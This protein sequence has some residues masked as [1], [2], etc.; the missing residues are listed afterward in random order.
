LNND[1]VNIKTNLNTKT[2]LYLYDINGR[3]IKT[4]DFTNEYK[5][6]L[7]NIKSGLYLIKIN[8]KVTKLIIQ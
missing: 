6:D 4:D 1:Y 2:K 3:L 8:S 7:Y 5:L